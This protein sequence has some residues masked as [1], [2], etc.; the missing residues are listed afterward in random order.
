MQNCTAS[1]KGNFVVYQQQYAHIFVIIKKHLEDLAAA[2]API[3]IGHLLV[4]TKNPQGDFQKQSVSMYVTPFSLLQ[5]TMG[6]RKEE[7]RII[8]S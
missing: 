1:E 8:T 6:P 4:A 7:I 2:A 5:S 3:K